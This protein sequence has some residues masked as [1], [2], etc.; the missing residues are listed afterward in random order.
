MTKIPSLA[1]CQKTI[2]QTFLRAAQKHAAGRLTQT[3]QHGR[4]SSGNCRPP[5]AQHL[6]VLYIRAARD[7]HLPKR[8]GPQ[9]CCHRL[10]LRDVHVHGHAKALRGAVLLPPASRPAEAMSEARKPTRSTPTCCTAALHG[11]SAFESTIYS[12]FGKAV[13]AH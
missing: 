10:N 3:G 11:Q 6:V 9:V 13:Q 2:Q 5:P 7:A 8:P 12:E 1:I 4:F